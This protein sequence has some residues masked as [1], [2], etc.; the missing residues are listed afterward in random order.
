LQAVHLLLAFQL[1]VVVVG[2]DVGWVQEALA[3][4]LRP[5]L[6]DTLS[7]T[8][9]VE[10]EIDERKLA[11]RYLQKIFQLPFWL[12]PL[13]TD[14]SDGGSYARYVK[15][16]LA[17]NLAAE[18]PGPLAGVA[19][20]ASAGA[21]KAGSALEGPKSDDELH[22]ESQDE[23]ALAEAMAT[24][25]LTP[26]EV[27][28]LASQAVGKLAGS[29]PRAVKRFANI[30]RLIRARLDGDERNL[31]LGEGDTPPEYPIVVILI[32]VEVGRPLEI[33][34]EFYARLVN[35]TGTSID[36]KGIDDNIVSALAAAKKLRRGAEISRADC[37]RWA[38]TARRY[39]FNKY[40]LDPIRPQL[41]VD[42][43]AAAA[44]GKAVSP[45]Q[46]A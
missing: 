14:G 13:S 26:A 17:R 46:P 37:E 33:A 1:F 9:D 10:T 38:R 45:V 28:F 42:P 12:R 24:V 18:G 23:S 27:E 21:D 3:H 40:V 41:A 25:R 34:D 6:R 2:V 5:T 39:S 35:S 44:T 7:G 31:L 22:R 29:E 16:L 11:I 4:E 36:L 20:K 8:N 43:Q 30:Y 15:S 19:T 32:A